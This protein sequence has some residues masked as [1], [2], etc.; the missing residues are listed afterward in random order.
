MLKGWKAE[1]KEGRRRSVDYEGERLGG[2]GVLN[3]R[4]VRIPA[5]R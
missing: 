2:G 5:L 3:G 4:A 1:P